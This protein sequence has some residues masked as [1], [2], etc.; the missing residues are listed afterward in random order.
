MAA[1]PTLPMDMRTSNMFFRQGIVAVEI[2]F[3]AVEISNLDI[4]ARLLMATT[5]T[6][7]VVM[8]TSDM[9]GLEL[10]R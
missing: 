7:P 1:T 2:L 3:V 6:L 10:E 5:P 9:L 8:R 4:Q